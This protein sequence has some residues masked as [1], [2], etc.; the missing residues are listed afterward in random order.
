MKKRTLLIF[1]VLL[2]C[3]K[4]PVESIEQ[5][6]LSI[7]Q[8]I[9]GTINHQGGTYA[10]GTELSLTASPDE[11]YVFSNWSNGSSQNPLELNLNTDTTVSANFVKRKY[12]FTLTISGEGTVKEEV[13]SK[14]KTSTEYTSG[15]VVRL[16]A[17]PLNGWIF[18]QWSGSVSSTTNPIEVTIDQIKEI[19]ASFEKAP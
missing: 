18:S 9:G 10:M 7:E 15:S 4:D 2:A 13:V 16:T 3:T 11:E 5:V 6:K 17:N 14:G 19:T 8:K 12:T 1:M